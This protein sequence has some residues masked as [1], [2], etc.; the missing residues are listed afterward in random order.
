MSYEPRPLTPSE[1]QNA[2]E[3]AEVI[4]NTELETTSPERSLARYVLD[5]IALVE[6]VQPRPQN[7]TEGHPCGHCGET[8]HAST[9]ALAVNYHDETHPDHT[10]VDPRHHS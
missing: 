5:L 10:L 3:C 6:R 7:L 4:L 2:R 9:R 1:V 8:Y